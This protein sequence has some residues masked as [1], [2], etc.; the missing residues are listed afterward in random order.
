MD[1]VGKKIKGYLDKK[2]IKQVDIAKQ[3]GVSKAYINALLAGRSKFGKEV[4]EIWQKEYGFSKSFLLT[5]EGPMLIDSSTQ[6]TNSD[7]ITTDTIADTTASIVATGNATQSIGGDVNI[8]N[9]SNVSTVSPSPPPS[10]T[11]QQCASCAELAVM[12][13]RISGLEKENGLLREHNAILK[14]LLK[15]QK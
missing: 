1:E 2:G 5:G 14:E 10:M 8:S 11:A 6:E 3:L 7:T 9:V 15:P 12:R 13:E 4:A